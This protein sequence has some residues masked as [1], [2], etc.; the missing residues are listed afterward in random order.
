MGKYSHLK[1]KFEQ[2]QLEKDQQA[3]VDEA[4]NQ[5]MGANVAELTSNFKEARKKKKALE[6]GVKE[7][8]V[9]LEALAQLLIALLEDQNLTKA[10]VN[11]V[12]MI[13]VNDE[14]YAS[15]Q[16]REKLL[17]WINDGHEEL[18]AVNWQQLNSQV[19]EALIAGLEIPPGVKV[20]IKS[21]VR[22]TAKEA[23]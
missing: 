18:L 20:F 5:L 22:F 21:G 15:M 7:L 14:P 19:K 11:G 8:N 12:G 23:D 13:S 4:K 10:V 2:V 6:N 3:K 1:G 9:E 17:A 16:D